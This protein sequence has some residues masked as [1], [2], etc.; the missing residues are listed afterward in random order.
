MTI[1]TR[2]TLVVFHHPFELKGVDRTLPPGEYRVM[3]DEQ[4][5][6]ELSFPVYRRVSTVIFAPGQPPHG[7]S[8]EMLTI[9]PRDFEAAQ[10]RDHATPTPLP[11]RSEWARSGNH[12]K[13]GSVEEPLKA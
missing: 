2:N 10:D 7:S 3:T 8:G 5:I 11:V 12:A 6:E 1:R 9:D 4:L 13:R